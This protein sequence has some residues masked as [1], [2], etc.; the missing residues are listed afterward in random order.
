MKAA[1]LYAPG[2]IPRYGDIDD[3]VPSE[4]QELVRVLAAS[5]KNIDKSLAAGTHYQTDARPWPRLV[6]VD[7]VV[8][9]ADGSRAYAGGMSG[10]MAEKAV[11]ARGMAFGVPEGLDPVLAAALPNP[12]LAAW[13]ALNGKAQFRSGQALLI[14]G[15]T[16]ASGRLAVHFAKEMGAARIIAVGRNQKMLQELRGVGADEIVSLSVPEVEI[17]EA[18]SRVLAHG[19]VDL[20]ID[21]LWGRPAELVLDALGGHDLEAG[22]SLTRYLQVGSMAGPSVNLKSTILRS[23]EIEIFGQGGGSVDRDLMARVPEVLTKLFARAAH[24][25]LSMNVE[26]VPL[27]DVA[28]AWNRDSE[29]RRIVF[30]P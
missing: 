13:F 8:E 10:F 5:L 23:A 26:R 27:S 9:R 2:E 4:G 24:G 3:P 12:G 29:G 19:H 25:G 22:A 14:L 7:A 28:S 6:G 15:A 1:L 11:I 30:V 21:Y 20:V 16:G 17:Q 18:L